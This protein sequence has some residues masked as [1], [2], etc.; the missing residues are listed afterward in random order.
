MNVARAGPR[1]LRTNVLLREASGTRK[2]QHAG[3]C[4]ARTLISQGLAPL[5]KTDWKTIDRIPT[6]D[7][8]LIHQDNE[9]TLDQSPAPVLKDIVT[10]DGKGESL[11]ALSSLS[12]EHSDSSASQRHPVVEKQG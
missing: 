11:R 4:D 9:Q 5:Y 3:H 8:P 7:Q 1:V 2:K 10:G 6:V 12:A